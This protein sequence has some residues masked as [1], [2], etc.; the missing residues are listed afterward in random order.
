MLID[1]HAHLSDPKF[2][3]DRDLVIKRASEN[4]IN[5][6]VEVGCEPYIWK[7][8]FRLAKLNPGIFCAFGIHPHEAKLAS[9]EL[10]KTLEDLLKY[11]KAV[12]VGETGLDYYYNHSPKEVQQKVLKLHIELAVKT[13]KPVIIHCRDAYKDLIEILGPYPSIKGV[14]HCFSGNV[15]EALRLIEMGFLLGIDGPITYPKAAVLRNVVKEIPLDKLV[16][17]TD[18]PYLPP[19]E[20]RGKRN[21]PSYLAQIAEETANIK[22][23]SIDE[24]STITTQNALGLFAL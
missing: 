13:G 6:I 9:P 5:K 18:S 8:S 10:L 21:E 3:I 2:S 19:Q 20:F 14:I 15:N 16:L 17:E 24:V 12:A 23:V 22:S 1:T 4:G 11:P 7:D